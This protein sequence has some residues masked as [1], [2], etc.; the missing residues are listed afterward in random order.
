VSLPDVD[1]PEIRQIRPTEPERAE[2]IELDPV[3]NRGAWGERPGRLLGHPYSLGSSTLLDCEAASGRSREDLR[4]SRAG[5]RRREVEREANA[6]WRLLFQ[7]DSSEPAAM[8]W[9]GGGL[10][11]YCIEREALPARDFSRVWL[12]MQSL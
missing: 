6:R 4:R 2:L 9:A 8:D 1:G 5:R 12:N 7:L 11:H 10:L 3:V